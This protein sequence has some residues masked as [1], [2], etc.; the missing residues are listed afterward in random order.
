[1]STIKNKLYQVV[2]KSNSR[3]GKLFD[4][5][6][7]VAIIISVMAV[8]AESVYAI[9]IRWGRLLLITEWT[10]TILFTIEYIVRIL[11]VRK[12]SGYIFSFYGIIDF[13][14]IIP[15]FLGLALAGA[16]NLVVLRL[17]RLMRVFRI[18]KLSRHTLA[19]N[20]ILKSL[21]ESQAKIGVFFTAVVTI[22][23]VI[24]TIMYIVEGAESG[25]TSIPKSIYWTI[26]TITT[27]GY[28]DIAPQTALGQFIA[29]ITMLMGYAIIAVPTG[30]VSA[31]FTRQKEN[32]NVST[33]NF[34]PQCGQ[35]I[36]HERES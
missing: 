36:N 18:L 14:S 5:I 15:T 30:I 6:L 23:V 34:C 9:E 11:I 35:L 26:V 3:A 1:M 13:L 33:S 31:E 2:F 32:E 17:L 28:G 19:G 25:F 29:S 4:I 20:T 7:I 16:K 24:G 10:I 21:K 12:K 8:M 22:V 27:V